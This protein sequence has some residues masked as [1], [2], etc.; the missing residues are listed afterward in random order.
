MRR[1]HPS[2]GL[3]VP[4]SQMIHTKRYIRSVK[5]HPKKQ[6]NAKVTRRPHAKDENKKKSRV[7]DKNVIYDFCGK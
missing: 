5:K 7:M 4:V 1:C 2:N 6:A 3:H